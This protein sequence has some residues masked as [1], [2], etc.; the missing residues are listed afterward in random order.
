M[1]DGI[2]TTLTRQSGLMR[3]MS[4]V[5]NNVA[6]ASTTGYRA[7]G[8]IF[9][10]YV[11]D[12][13]EGHPSLSMATGNGHMTR[14]VQGALGQTNGTYDLA[15]EGDGFFQIEGPDGLQLTR[16]GAFMPNDAGDL[17]TPEGLRVLDAGGAPIFIP[18]DVANVHISADGTI[19]ADGRLLAQ[20][21]LVMPVDPNSLD[22]TNGVSFKTD[23][24][25]EPVEDGRI[26]QGFLE[27]SNVDAV[28]EISRMIQ[29]QHA[30][31]MGQAF[32]ER[33]DERMRSVTQLIGR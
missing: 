16:A 4:M 33:E 23:G 25:L 14:T 18:P 30:Y 2:Y 24:D 3:E 8:L 29:V 1:A 27:G 13:G 20:I 28:S 21:G 6:N 26:L 17:V 10:E 32:M 9:S 15:I 19:S 22:R 31:Q 12:L 11:K 5:A 7:E